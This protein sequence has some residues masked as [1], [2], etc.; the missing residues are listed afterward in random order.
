MNF[1][2]LI[3]SIKISTAVVAVVSLA[4]VV[5]FGSAFLLETTLGSA[6]LIIWIV[7]FIFC[8]LTLGIYLIEI[9]E[10]D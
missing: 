2:A 7:I 1:P 9:E 4:I 6:G 5:I 8:C 3:K 10:E